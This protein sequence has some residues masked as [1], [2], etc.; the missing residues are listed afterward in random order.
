MQPSFPE[1]LFAGRKHAFRSMSRPARPLLSLTVVALGLAALAPEAR[2]DPDWAIQNRLAADFAIWASSPE[3]EVLTGDFNKDGR[4]DLALVRKAP[5]WTTVPVA[6]ATA[7][8]FI[9]QNRPAQ[10][11]AIWASSPEVKVLT[12]DFNKDGRTDL[13]LVRQAPGW[14]TVPVALATANGFTIQNRPAADFAIWASSPQVEVVTGDFNGDGRTDISLVR[15]APGW[16]TVPVALATANGFTI[17]N[18]PA[19]D[20][21]IWASSPQVKVLSGDFNGDNRSDLA[22]LLQAPGWTTVPVALSGNSGFTI[23]NR[24]AADFALWASSPE[25][26]PLTGDFNADKRTDLALVRQ[27]PGWTTVPVALSR[28]GSFIVQNP[29]AFDFAGWAASP[30]VR[31][32]SGRFNGDRRSD[33]ALVRQAPGWTT[34][35]V[36]LSND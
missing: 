1:Y 35:P 13:A 18:R 2:G 6:L 19:A 21:A 32:L 34:V 27:S 3:V 14:T 36:A 28:P 31:V 4:T 23:Q 15:K 30:V 7:S 24:P 33:L 17:Q 29:P 5:G 12:G 11:F 22:L 10:D 26:T 16:T 20:F 8:G 9:I 25:V